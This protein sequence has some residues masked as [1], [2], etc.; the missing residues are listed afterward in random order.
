MVRKKV[1]AEGD[2]PPYKSNPADPDDSIKEQEYHQAIVRE[3]FPECFD[4]AEVE[5]AEEVE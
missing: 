5:E 3:K 2:F 1:D 4:D